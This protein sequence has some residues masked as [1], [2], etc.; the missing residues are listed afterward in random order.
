M[1]GPVALEVRYAAGSGVLLGAGSRW[2]LLDVPDPD[3]PQLEKIWD[4]LTAPTPPAERVLTAVDERYGADCS[5]V[6]VDLTPG[7]ETRVARGTGRISNVDGRRLLRLRDEPGAVARRLVSGIVAASGADLVPVAVPPVAVARAA[8]AP[9]PT[10]GMI[11]GIPPEILAASAPERAA[12]P[13]PVVRRTP[14]HTARRSS[15]TDHDGQTTHRDAGL[16]AGEVDHLRQTTHETVLAVHCPA[17][18][19]T[20]AFTA[21]CRVCQVA[22]PPQEPHRM[23]R[24]RLGVLHL[25]DGTEVPLDRGVVFGRQPSAPPA[26]EDWPQLVRLPPDN[27]YVSRN[28]LQ[29][30]LDGW[31]VLAT[32]LGSR[33]G[34]TLRIPGRAAERIRSGERYIWEPGQVFDLADSCEILYEV[35]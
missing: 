25:P 22:V 31:L 35:R 18:H 7:A 26:G 6:L 3:D 1:P 28:H 9:P 5:L 30:E 11:D 29:V 8:P 15:D 34:T 24:P 12:P 27:G 20:P 32:D 16:D 17:G 10:P 13:P 14:E 23:P 4:L 2:L 33:G 21:N 19:P